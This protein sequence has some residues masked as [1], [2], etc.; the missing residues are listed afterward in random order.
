MRILQGMGVALVIVGMGQAVYALAALVG[1]V[2][3]LSGRASAFAGRT[4]RRPRGLPGRL[5][6]RSG[7]CAAG[8]GC[9]GD[10]VAPG[11]KAVSL[12]QQRCPACS[13]PL[14]LDGAPFF[15]GLRLRLTHPTILYPADW[16]GCYEDHA[17]HL[18]E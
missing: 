8:A 17:R 16:A 10:C 13:I 7:L 15:G 14:G 11:S 3:A 6:D 4:G 9:A 2:D 18:A 12:W 1:G 5:G